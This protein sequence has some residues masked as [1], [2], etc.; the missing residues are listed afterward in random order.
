MLLY[1][2]C[3]D[4]PGDLLDYALSLDYEGLVL[5]GTGAGGLPAWLR[6]K[7]MNLNQHI[8]CVLASR[9]GHGDIVF[10]SYGR[11]FQQI[12]YEQGVCLSN[13]LDSRKS[14]I[15]LTLLLSAEFSR[16]DIWEIFKKFSKFAGQ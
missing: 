16:V 11:G 6:T 10:S 9:T 4:D 13:I 3:M 5:E 7:L 12:A 15:L 2:T 14:R 8:P 1:T